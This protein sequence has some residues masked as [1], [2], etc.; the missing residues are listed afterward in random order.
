MP[1]VVERESDQ[2]EGAAEE[3]QNAAERRVPVLLDSNRGRDAP[4]G[5]EDDGQEAA[6]GDA[7]EAGEDRIVGDRSEWA[8]IAAGVDVFGDVPVEAEG[9]DE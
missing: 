6:E 8:R 5:A 3:D 4:V 2:R 9:R 7:G 1:D